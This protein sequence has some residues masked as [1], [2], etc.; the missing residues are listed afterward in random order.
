M[1]NIVGPWM[2]VDPLRKA[3][4]PLNQTR[5]LRYFTPEVYSKNTGMLH[6]RIGLFDIAPE[7]LK[8]PSEPRGLSSDMSHDAETSDDQVKTIRAWKVEV[9]RRPSDTRDTNK[10]D[11]Y[12]RAVKP[13]PTT[14]PPGPG[15]GSSFKL[16][17]PGTQQE[18]AMSSQVRDRGHVDKEWVKI[19]RF[20]AEIWSLRSRIHEMR[21]ILRERQIAKSEA[22]DKYFKYVR[23]R[24]LGLAFG[25]Q[26]TSNEQKTMEALFHDCEVARDEYGPFEDDCNLLENE[27]G[28]QEFE[29]Q[30]LEGKFYDRPIELL[31]SRSDVPDTTHNSP[32]ASNYS[33]FELNQQFHPLVSEYLSKIGDVEIIRERLD[34]HVEEKYA[35]EEEKETR[36]RVNV[37]LAELD[38]QWLDNYSNTENDLLNQLEVA[39][40]EVEK[41]R[42]ECFSRGLVDEEGNATDF[43]H[44]ERQTFVADVDAGSEISEYIKFPILIPRPGSKQV[45]L[46]SSGP[47]PDETLHDSSVRVDQWLLHQLRMSALEVNLLA[48]IFESQFGHIKEGAS[49]QIDVLAF[50]C[51]FSDCDFPN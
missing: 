51:I 31:V 23:M 47:D 2:S 21:R 5:K 40:E 34:W 42:L 7:S 22:D 43:D 38:Q 41:L 44:R 18:T 19:K 17:G 48:R 37:E 45:Q 24:G 36:M 9:S 11:E 50:V 3:Q 35:L 12:P 10:N 6:S 49:W 1:D 25:N 26:G 20:R 27:L 46:H 33:G 15:P 30:K 16:P 32:T 8:P 13:S 28:N 4:H 29:L 14:R 39:E